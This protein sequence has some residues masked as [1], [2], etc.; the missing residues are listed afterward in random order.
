MN[1]TKLL[2]AGSR[3]Y[4]KKRKQKQETVDRIDFDFDAR[5]EFLTGFHKRK[6]DRKKKAREIAIERER[7]DRLQARAEA[8]EERQRLAD[9]NMTQMAALLRQQHKL[10]DGDGEADEEDGDDV[11]FDSDEEVEATEPA[12][13][14]EPAVKEFATSTSLTTVTVIQ[15]L[16]LDDSY[17]SSTSNKRKAEED[18]ADEDGEE[19]KTIPSK[20]K[21]KPTKK[22]M[23][24]TPK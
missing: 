11:K 7:V 5:Q 19:I 21:E 15:D 2:S 6:L 13:K 22:V 18:V 8:R 24:K 20:T 12:A 14:L 9:N 1:N 3:I 16:E 10:E 23:T 17:Q 4:A